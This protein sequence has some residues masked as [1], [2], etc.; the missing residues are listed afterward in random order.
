LV[1]PSPID[2]AVVVSALSLSISFI[3]LSLI[4][5]LLAVHDLLRYLTIAL[6]FFNQR[7]LYI[8]QFAWSEGPFTALSL[9]FIYLL[10]KHSK[11]NRN[12]YLYLAAF[13]T[14]GIVATRYLGY[15]AIVV[16]LLYMAFYIYTKK[17]YAFRVL[18]PFML[19]SLIAILPGLL[20]VIRN[21]LFDGTLH[22]PRSPATI[23]II[24][25]LKL[26]VRIFISDW[27][28]LGLSILF[29]LP[30]FPISYYNRFKNK[31]GEIFSAN[32]DI[33]ILLIAFFT[34]VS[35][36][37]YSA[38][39]ARF[40]TLSTRFFAPV[41]PLFLIIYMQGLNIVIKDHFNNRIIAYFS[42]TIVA[43]Y[44]A[45]Y[46]FFP[47]FNKDFSSNSQHNRLGFSQSSTKEDLT[48][49]FADIL[50]EFE[51]LN[52]IIFTDGDRK[53]IHL[54]R[55]L[56]F[57]P[58]LFGSKK[59]ECYKPESGDLKM[60]FT[61]HNNRARSVKYLSLGQLEAVDWLENSNNIIYIFDDVAFKEAVELGFKVDSYHHTQVDGY[62]LFRSA[63][64]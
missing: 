4:L 64:P 35:L 41:Y 9:V 61:D 23:T 14:A 2:A 63:K 31:C 57:Y 16:F 25:N 8:F 52:L 7:Y 37:L 22:G 10:L 45:I 12:I 49:Y 18:Y 38:S 32:I 50:D 19:A 21:Y 55:S 36:V 6:L 26:F 40:D 15:Y 51:H 33:I 60:D 46:S 47:Y 3:F 62:H 43:I 5:R 30:L 11:T 34:Y 1:M 48:H 44:M 53:R 20:W 24:S 56:L 58:E 17:K 54:S 29:L 59:I 28:F 27:R 42:V 13:C 39:T